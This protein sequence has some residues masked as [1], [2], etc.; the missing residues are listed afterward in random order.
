MGRGLIRLD[1][2]FPG[3]ARSNLRPVR[4][5]RSRFPSIY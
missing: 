3:L 1:G 2:T 5:F 4:R